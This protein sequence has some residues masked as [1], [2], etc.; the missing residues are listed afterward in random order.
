VIGTLPTKRKTWTARH[1][2]EVELQV[3]RVIANAGPRGIGAADACDRLNGMDS[4]LLKV[5]LRGLQRNG[6]VRF[7][8]TNRWGAW[9]ATGVLPKDEPG[10]TWLRNID[11]EPGDETPT[12]QQT[13]SKADQVL[14][15]ARWVPNSAFALGAKA[16]GFGVDIDAAHMPADHKAAMAAPLDPALETVVSFE[17]PN[18]PLAETEATPAAEVVADLV[19]DALPP[20]AQVRESLNAG[21]CAPWFSF[22]S[23]NTLTIALRDGRFVILAEDETRQLFRYLDRLMAI[24]HGSLSEATS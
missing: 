20:S 18:K 2:D 5:H 24:G 1:S 21:T 17:F 13:A 15:A 9:V 23:D 12:P 4:E 22:C 3:W 19:A 11:P 8:G 7:V 14:A 10:P 6:H 16:A